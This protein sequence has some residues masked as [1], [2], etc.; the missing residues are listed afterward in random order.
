MRRRMWSPPPASTWPA[1]GD[2]WLTAGMCIIQEF[3]KLVKGIMR[4]LASTRDDSEGFWAEIRCVGRPGVPSERMRRRVW[5][6][7]QHLPDW[8]NVINMCWQGGQIMILCSQTY[9]EIALR[10]RILETC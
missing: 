5:S 8:T 3:L 7:P 10:V 1:T 9:Y 6:P 4:F 2:H